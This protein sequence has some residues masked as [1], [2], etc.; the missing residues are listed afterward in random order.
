MK[1]RGGLD[2]ELVRRESG[3][4]RHRRSTQEQEQGEHYHGGQRQTA[5]AGVHRAQPGGVGEVTVEGPAHPRGQPFRRFE[6]RGDLAVGQGEQEQRRQGQDACRAQR[7]GQQQGGQK[8][9]RRTAL[10][11]GQHPAGAGKSQA[12]QDLTCAIHVK[13]ESSETHL[14]AP[15]GR[16]RPGSETHA[17]AGSSRKGW[18]G[19]PERPPRRRRR[20]A[21]RS[22]NRRC[23]RP[24]RPAAARGAR[25]RRGG[26][27]GGQ[28]E[29][30]RG[31]WPTAPRPSATAP[32]SCLAPCDTRSA[33]HTA[34]TMKIQLNTCGRAIQCRL[35]VERR[36]RGHQGRQQEVAAHQ[37]VQPE[38]APDSR[39]DGG[40]VKHR[41]AGESGPPVRQAHRHVRS[42]LPGKPRPALAGE[43]V[44]IGARQSAGRENRLTVAD[45]P[46]GIGI[47]KQLLVSLKK[48]QAVKQGDG[49]GY[50][51]EVGD[52]RT[53]RAQVNDALRTVPP[54]GGQ[55]A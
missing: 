25:G 37:P 33:H 20:N 30:W 39:R 42:P 36:G 12:R 6:R 45:M 27:P 38:P 44:R 35:Q 9:P 41:Y 4:G 48:E 40:G 18:R 55:T 24:P 19:S 1:L 21:G 2:G 14:C 50:Q 51:G 47:A 32:S 53:Y 8:E 3:A 15:A 23:G 54:D 43:R 52:Q 28:T 49:G 13:V 7:G 26:T 34:A 10:P 5:K 11:Q 29:S 16:C 22:A 46:A 17:G 31:G